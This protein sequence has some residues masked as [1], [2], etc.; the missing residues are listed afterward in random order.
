MNVRTT[1]DL[2]A[3][4]R[5][6]RHALKLDQKT[7]AE[8]AGVSRYWIIDIEAGKPRAEIGLVLKTLRVL[9]LVLDIAPNRLKPTKGGQPRQSRMPEVDLD[10]LIKTLSD[11]K[12]ET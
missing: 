12:S 5:D 10:A 8:R 7:L 9:D 3:L 11:R 1:T 2:G 4:I 6:R